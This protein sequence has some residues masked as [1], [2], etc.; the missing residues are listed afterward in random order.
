[1]TDMVT[2]AK[3]FIITIFQ[4]PFFSDLAMG[5]LW[6]GKEKIYLLSLNLS[7]ITI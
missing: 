3:V 5:F 1:M 4:V 6:F 2:K 7:K